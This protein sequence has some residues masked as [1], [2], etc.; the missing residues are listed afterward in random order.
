MRFF[1]WLA[2]AVIPPC[3]DLRS[4]GWH[5]VESIASPGEVRV[6][7]LTTDLARAGLLGSRR[8]RAPVVILGA[9]DPDLRARLL[10]DGFGEALSSDIE[11]AELERRVLRVAAALDSLPRQRI[12]GRLVLD[13]LVRDGWVSDRRIGLHPREF[14]LLWR[15]AE[16]PGEPVE[17]NELLSD[18]W[19]L[20]FRPE[21]NSLAVHVCRLR[22]KLAV[23]GLDKVVATTPSGAYVLT[24]S[25]DVT[26]G[27]RAVPLPPGRAELDE[28]VRVPPAATARRGEQV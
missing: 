25:G 11:L 23:A 17:A 27:A 12:H 22:A 4:L 9:D 26:A 14:A 2:C 3:H 6:P 15:L 13:L 5:L 20:N 8:E 18:V 24:G 16:T 21:T 1:G 10:A 7:L 19:Q 28:H